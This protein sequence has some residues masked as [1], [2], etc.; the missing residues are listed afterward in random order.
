MTSQGT[1]SLK[2]GR[3]TI[4]EYQTHQEYQTRQI[5][6]I[7]KKLIPLLFAV[8]FT[9]SACTPNG[10]KESGTDGAATT[11]TDPVQRISAAQFMAEQKADAVVLDVRTPQEFASGHLAEAQNI[12]FRSAEF[13][14]MVADLDRDQTYYLYCRSGNRSGQASEI[15]AE[16]GFT[17][18]YNI[19]GLADLESAGATVIK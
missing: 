9:F 6:R 5:D 19:G 10:V 1:T 3:N 16:M 2:T 4:K 12:D 8:L 17:S 18:L 15:M 7:M 11:Q 14:N 13:R